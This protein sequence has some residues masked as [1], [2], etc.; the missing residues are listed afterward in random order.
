MRARRGAGP[1]AVVGSFLSRALVS[2]AALLSLVAVGSLLACSE[3]LP[4]QIALSPQ[5]EQIE[6][7]DEPMPAD[8]Y[9]EIGDVTGEGDRSEPAGSRAERA[10]RS[11]QSY[12]RDGRELRVD[13]VAIDRGVRLLQRPRE[14]VDQR[15]RRT[16]RVRS[17]QAELRQLGELGLLEGP[18]LRREDRAACLHVRDF[19]IICPKGQ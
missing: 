10:E 2:S 11:A 1:G 3:E 19:L 16:R 17:D 14:A 15:D 18:E 13:R 9:K 8:Q 6:T 4:S 5:G 12:L 7:S